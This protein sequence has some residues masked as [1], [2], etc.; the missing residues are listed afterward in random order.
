MERGEAVRCGRCN[1]TRPAG[2]Q[3]ASGQFAEQ[4]DA[5]RAERWLGEQ[6]DS[7]ASAQRAASGQTGDEQKDYSASTAQRAEE[8]LGEQ[9]DCS[10]GGP[11]V[12]SK[13]IGSE[14]K[15]ASVSRR[16]A[17]R[18]DGAQR[19]GRRAANV[20]RARRAEGWHGERKDGSGSGRVASRGWLRAPRADGWLGEHTARSERED[21]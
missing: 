8:W 14:R 10:A 13:Q 5:Q 2:P 11:R 19:A 16:M 18:A 20:R 9:T 7:S 6:M 1:V 12:V 17:R 21:G 3:V 4:T 15:D